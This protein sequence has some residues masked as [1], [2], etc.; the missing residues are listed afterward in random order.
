MSRIQ[1]VCT[2]FE[3][4][5]TKRVKRRQVGAEALEQRLELG[6]TKISR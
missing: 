5:M 2:K 1:P 4:S 6:I 3:M